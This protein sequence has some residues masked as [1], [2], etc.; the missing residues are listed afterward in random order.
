MVSGPI[1]TISSRSASPAT[2][3]GRTS[4]DMAD[5]IA[6]ADPDRD[7]Y[8]FWRGSNCSPS[9]AALPGARL[10]T[11]YAHLEFADAAVRGGGAALSGA[12]RAG[13]RGTNG[14][15]RINVDLLTA[16]FDYRLTRPDLE[17][18]TFSFG[19]CP[20]PTLR[21]ARASARP[22]LIRDLS[23]RNSLNWRPDGAVRLLAGI[24][25]HRT[26]ST[27]PST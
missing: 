19:D 5:G 8:G 24:S 16:V 13:A 20:V 25:R 22:G 9:R 23:P 2:C 3:A 6:G 11:T 4:S 14:I 18:T 1:V 17:P 10:E 26:R 15:F 7:D 21:P 27:S 12:A